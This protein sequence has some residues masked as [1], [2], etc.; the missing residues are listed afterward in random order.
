MPPYCRC[1]ILLYTPLRCFPQSVPDRPAS[2]KSHYRSRHRLPYWNGQVPAFRWQHTL[3]RQRNRYRNCSPD[4]SMPD[5]NFVPSAV[6]HSAVLSPLQS[7]PAPPFRFVDHFPDLRCFLCSQRPVLRKSCK[8]RRQR[9]LKSVLHKLSVLH[10]I[11][12]FSGDQRR[13]RPVVIAKQTLVTQS[14][15]YIMRRGALPVK[16]N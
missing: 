1:P 10:R 12:L 15:Q 13:H 6:W 11:E 3:S 16:S 7:P 4:K 14:A 8:K 2:N 5:S 9:A